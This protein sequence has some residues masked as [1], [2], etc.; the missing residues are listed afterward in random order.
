MSTPE[1]DIFLLDV[2]ALELRI[3]SLLLD[4]KL[5]VVE[6]ALGRVLAKVIA[7]DGRHDHDKAMQLWG[8]WEEFVLGQIA[9]NCGIMP[10]PA[11]LPSHA[12]TPGT[13]GSQPPKRRP[14]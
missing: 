1:R 9:I 2:T 4:K 6:A 14:A 13:P 5:T 10:K 11:V 7:E 3:N 12:A 8:S